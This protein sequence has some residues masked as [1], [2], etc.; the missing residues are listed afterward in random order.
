MDL[1]TAALAKGF[2][3]VVWGAFD[4]W[5]ESRNSLVTNEDGGCYSTAQPLLR[6]PAPKDTADLL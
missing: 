4:E 5:R 6:L 3:F 1:F 2:I